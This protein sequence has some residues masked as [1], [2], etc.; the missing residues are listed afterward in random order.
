MVLAH[1]FWLWFL[2]PSEVMYLFICVAQ[3][4][5]ITN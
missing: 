1:Y 2:P 3:E 4:G 5:Y